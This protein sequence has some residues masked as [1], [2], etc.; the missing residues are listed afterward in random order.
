MHILKA[1]LALIA[2]A[3]KWVLDGYTYDNEVP[4][5]PL[6]VAVGLPFVV[7]V[8]TLFGGACVT[9]FFAAGRLI[10]FVFCPLIG[11]CVVQ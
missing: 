7:F 3:Y 11:G 4:L 5:K 9:A 1:L 6:R 8:I 2:S 10:G